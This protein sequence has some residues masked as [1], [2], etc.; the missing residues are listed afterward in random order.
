VLCSH[1]S[2]TAH[3]RRKLLNYVTT[4]ADHFL[5]IEWSEYTIVAIDFVSC[6][7]VSRGN[8][9]NTH[10]KDGYTT[11]GN[12]NNNEPIHVLNIACNKTIVWPKSPKITC[13]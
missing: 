3:P 8:S 5:G 9:T 2:K 10:Y 12:P 7:C 4:L 13:G 11:G 1:L 6:Y